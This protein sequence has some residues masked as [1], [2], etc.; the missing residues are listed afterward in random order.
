MMDDAPGQYYIEY[1]AIGSSVKVTAI[2]PVTTIEVSIVAD[3]KTPQAQLDA[4]AVKKLEYM[5]RKKMKRE[6]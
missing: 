3:R 6:D 4:L 2:D 1:T 5:I